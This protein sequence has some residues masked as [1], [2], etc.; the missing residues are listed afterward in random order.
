MK[1]TLFVPLIALVVVMS[2]CRSDTVDLAYS[3]EEGSVLRYR[4][5]TNAQAQWDIEGRNGAGA[6]EIT[7]EITE[8]IDSV[9]D[10][11]AVV[12]V[13]MDVTDFEERGLSSP[14]SGQTSFKV[15]LGPYGEK[16]EVLDVDGVPAAELSQEQRA[17]INTYRP[18]LP[19]DPIALHGTWPATQALDFPNVTQEIVAQGELVSLSK[20]HETELATL[21]YSWDGP[22]EGT[23][24]LPQGDARISGTEET[25]AVVTFDLTGGFPRSQT[26]TTNATFDVSIEAQ[27]GGPRSQGILT[28]EISSD[29]QFL[30]RTES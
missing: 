24:N 18:A 27:G 10:G 20:D 19:L 1:R 23:L 28:Q 2:A 15:R 4:M 11:N 13:T 22:L 5:T 26:A 8:R 29:L 17:L 9:E 14:G 3:Y 25:E 30:E 12:A 16:L 21:D 7:Y 6:Y